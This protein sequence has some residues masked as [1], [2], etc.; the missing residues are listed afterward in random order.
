VWQGTGAAGR[1]PRICRFGVV[2]R[3]GQSVV[4]ELEMTAALDNRLADALEHG[5]AAEIA[6]VSKQIAQNGA[7]LECLA[8]ELEMKVCGRPEPE[9]E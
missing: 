2:A 8:D 9:R 5:S 1:R 6:A 4:A 3:P 7:A